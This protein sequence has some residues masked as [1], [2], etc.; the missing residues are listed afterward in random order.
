MNYQLLSNNYQSNN[1]KNYKCK[2]YFIN[3]VS[4]ILKLIKRIQKV[5]V[6][7]NIIQNIL[8]QL[9]K[10]YSKLQRKN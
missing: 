5:I 2:K 6:R 8:Q 3:H 10:H 7:L 1:Q 4:Y 9:H